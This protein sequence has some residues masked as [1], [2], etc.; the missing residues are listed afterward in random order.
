MEHLIVTNE[1]IGANLVSSV[2]HAQRRPSGA[3]S[4]YGDPGKVPGLLIGVEAELVGTEGTH[5]VQWSSEGLYHRRRNPDGSWT[6][7][8]P[9][10]SNHWGRLL[11]TAGTNVF[12]SGVGLASVTNAGQAELHVCMA[13][14]GK[15]WH[16]VRR[17]DPSLGWTPLAQIPTM[18]TRGDW[19]DVDCTGNGSELEVAAIAG[20]NNG[21]IFTTHRNGDGSWRAAQDITSTATLPG[22]VSVTNI[23]GTLHFLFAQL[24]NNRLF[25]RTFD[26]AFGWGTWG[27]PDIAQNSNIADVSAT[28]IGGTLNVMALGV[29]PSGPSLS[30][31]NPMHSSVF[32]GCRKSPCPGAWSSFV[33]LDTVPEMRPIPRGIIGLTV[34][35]SILP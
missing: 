15:L 3:W 32:G 23:N 24:N 34:A 17:A 8:G 18:L 16:Q 35:A 30:G 31:G 6:D 9:A 7:S 12:V 22:K 5:I 11:D 14:G 25:Y 28:N 2:R 1:A 19:K 21:F 33:G 27:I 20:S 4:G 10:A 13:R 29:T 26:P